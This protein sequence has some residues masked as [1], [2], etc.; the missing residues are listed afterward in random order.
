MLEAKLVRTYDRSM[1]E[2]TSTEFFG[3]DDDPHEAKKLYRD[4]SQQTEAM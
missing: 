3:P 4:N 1:D 2:P